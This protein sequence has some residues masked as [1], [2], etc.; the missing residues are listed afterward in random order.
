M[1]ALR[2]WARESLDE[3]YETERIRRTEE[4]MK[5]WIF[6]KL[7]RWVLLSWRIGGHMGDIPIVI[8]YGC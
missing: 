6:M 2:R 7:E 3:E 8:L 4:Q 5:L 1:V